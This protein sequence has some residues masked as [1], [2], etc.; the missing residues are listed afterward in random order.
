M[1][2]DPTMPDNLPHGRRVS[3]V[4]F[5]LPYAREIRRAANGDVPGMPRLKPLLLP[6][7]PHSRKRLLNGMS[8]FVAAA[9]GN[10]V[11]ERIQF[12]RKL[13][14]HLIRDNWQSLGSDVTLGILW[15]AR[16]RKALSSRLSLSGAIRLQKNRRT[17]DLKQQ[18]NAAYALWQADI[19]T[20]A[21]PAPVIHTHEGHSLEQLTT[22]RH[23][24][25]IG[26]EARNCLAQRIGDD[27]IAHPNYWSQLTR[28]ERHFFALR[29]GGVLLAVISIAPPYL[30]KMQVL[31][32]RAT[33]IDILKGCVPAIEAA[34]GHPIPKSFRKWLG[35]DQAD[36][37][38]LDQHEPP[39][40][41]VDPRL[42]LLPDGGDT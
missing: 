42:M 26:R 32:S 3:A 6:K 14:A 23:L 31:A 29:H 27:F 17:H 10:T 33:V 18:L 20:P 36:T 19:V 35:E 37:P 28:G 34:T 30:S 13:A 15:F 11:D 25:D 22:G 12:A 21:A 5:L 39:P 16:N 41:M 8:S 1:A 38:S 40:S 7:R 2:D 24:A 4:P 9:P